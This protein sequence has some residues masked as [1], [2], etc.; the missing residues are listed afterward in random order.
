MLSSVDSESVNS[1]KGKRD[2][3]RISRRMNIEDQ[4]DLGKRILIEKRIDVK[5]RD[6][7]VRIVMEKLLRLS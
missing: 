3:M 2:L 7:L 5:S 6:D 1:E 4:Q